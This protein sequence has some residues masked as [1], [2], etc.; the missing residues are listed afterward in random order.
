V[1]VAVAAG[2]VP[3]FEVR[4]ADLVARGV[5]SAF[6]PE[7]E[8]AANATA[9]ASSATANGKRTTFDPERAKSCLPPPAITY[10]IVL[11][12]LTLP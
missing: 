6:E 1:L 5:G 4:E 9:A 10:R 2:G 8:Q 12:R 7:L 11:E 3:A